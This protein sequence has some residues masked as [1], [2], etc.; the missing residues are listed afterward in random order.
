MMPGC[1]AWLPAAACAATGPALDIFL[2]LIPSAALAVLL[3]IASSA[4]PAFFVFTTAGTLC[5]ELAHFSVGLLTNA[6]P[7][8]MSVFPRRIKQPKGGHNWELGSVTFANL[9]WYNA[10]PAALAPLLVLL[11]PLGVAWWRTRGGL[12]FE[13]LDLAIMFFLAPQF[14]SFWPSPVD[15]KLAA[16]SWPWAPLLALALACW[17]FREEVLGIIKA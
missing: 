16:R 7:V 1:S 14:L 8:G 10:A 2:Y 15:W 4:H 11:V 5:H 17:Y 9:R 13:P 12:A 3:W 6:E